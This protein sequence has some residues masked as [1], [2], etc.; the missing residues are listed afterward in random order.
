M[1]AAVTDPERTRRNPVVVGVLALAVAFIAFMW[2]YAFVFAD[3]DGINRIEDRA[4]SAR[5]E[6]TCADARTAL[7]ELADYRTLEEVGEGALAARADLVEQANAVLDDMIGTLE[8]DPPVGDKAGRIIPA[9]LADYRTYLG[10]RAAYVDQLR[11]GD[12]SVFSETQINGS[13]ISNFIGDVA[14]QNEMPSCQV[15]LD[16]AV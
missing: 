5:A 6:Q 15:P 10:D 12:G 3:D 9:W 16:L 7:L 2:V 14:R 8:A 4:W 13:P 11:T 1:N